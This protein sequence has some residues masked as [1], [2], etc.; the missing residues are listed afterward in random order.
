MTIVTRKTSTVIITST[1]LLTDEQRTYIAGQVKDQLPSDVGVV[2]L[3]GGLTAQ[4]AGAAS[5]VLVGHAGLEID[6]VAGELMRDE[7]PALILAELQAF[8]ADLAR[9]RECRQSLST[10]ITNTRIKL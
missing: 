2:V 1:Y 7:T 3:D 6:F 10:R 9:E 5:V 4:V 8:R